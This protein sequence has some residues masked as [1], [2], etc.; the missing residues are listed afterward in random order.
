MMIQQTSLL[1]YQDVL[2]DLG[3]RH[4]EVMRALIRIQPASNKALAEELHWSIN[5]VTPRV[6]ELRTMQNPK[7]EF[8]GFVVE[9][10][11]KVMAWRAVGGILE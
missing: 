5:R 8:W 7:V 9:G 2:Q 10:G 6:Y 4:F 3:R 1:A 11:R